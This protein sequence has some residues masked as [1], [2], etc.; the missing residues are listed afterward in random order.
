MTVKFVTFVFMY[1]HQCLQIVVLSTNLFIHQQILLLQ[2]VMEI[3]PSAGGST[4]HGLTT[5]RVTK[6]IERMH[7]STET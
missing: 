6:S 5:N 2:V 7:M 3:S 4:H 1:N